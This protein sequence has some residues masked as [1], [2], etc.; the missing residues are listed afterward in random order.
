MGTS[1]GGFLLKGSMGRKTSLWARTEA[2]GVSTSGL[3][4]LFP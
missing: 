2:A 3:V 4:K 1:A